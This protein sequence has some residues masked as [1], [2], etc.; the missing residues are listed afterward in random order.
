RFDRY[1]FC[2][3]DAEKLDSL[4]QRVRRGYSD[5]LVEF[6]HGDSNRKTNEILQ[7]IPQGNK[8]FKVLVFCFADPY[9]LKSLNFETIKSLSE[10]LV[11]FLILIPSGMDANRNYE[12]HYLNPENKTIDKFVGT[13]EWRDEWKIASP[14]QSFDIFLTN[15]FGRRMKELRYN[16]EGIESTQQGH[17]N[18]LFL[19]VASK[20]PTFPH[21][22]HKRYSGRIYLEFAMKEVGMPIRFLR[23]LLSVIGQYQRKDRYK[24]CNPTYFS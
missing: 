15:Y 12:T 3:K 20:N 2:E 7:K 24:P 22:S 6:I 11:D 10:R 14:N 8:S 19:P 4:M 9:N 16:Y 5:V 18:S 1:I 17:L 21:P 23:F 13:S